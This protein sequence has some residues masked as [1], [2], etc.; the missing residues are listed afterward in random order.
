MKIITRSLS[1]LFVLGCTATPLFA[2]NCDP[3]IPIDG[4]ISAL[5]AAGAGYG[6]KKIYDQK[7]NK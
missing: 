6:M 4:G 7:K 1:L 5:I 3:N 2:Q